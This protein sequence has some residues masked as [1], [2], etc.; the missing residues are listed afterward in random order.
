VSSLG[1]LMSCCV[2]LELTAT[3]T[4]QFCPWRSLHK[5]DHS[6]PGWSRGWYVLRN[7][8]HVAR[9][10]TMTAA[11]SPLQSTAVVHYGC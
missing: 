9:N 5:P 8:S 6:L 7:I 11:C 1:N 2:Q 3:P 10:R 4:A